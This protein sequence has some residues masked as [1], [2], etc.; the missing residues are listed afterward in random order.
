ML[1]IEQVFEFME[2][3]LAEDRLAGNRAGLK[4]TQTAAGFL[5]AAANYAGDRESAR[6]FRVLA[7]EAANKHEELGGDE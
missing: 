3:V 1:T 6:R 4:N 5:M 2:R 7:A